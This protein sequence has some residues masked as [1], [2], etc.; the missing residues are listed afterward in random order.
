[1]LSTYAE[2]KN[3]ISSGDTVV[4]ILEKYLTA[5]EE[6]KNLNAFLEV[7]EESARVQ[8]EKVD[9]KIKDGTA[10]RLAGMVVGLKDNFC[11]QGHKVSASSK[12]LEGFESLFTGTAVERLINEDAIIIG[13]LN[14]DE[15]AM[16]SSNENSAFGPVRNPH[17]T[18][19]VP[20]GSSGGSAAAVAAGMCTVAL[21]SDT[22]GSIRQ[23][24]SFTGTFGLKPTYGR[25]SRHGLIAY[26]S[27]F[28]QIGPFT[29]SIDD[30][31]LLLEVMAGGDE[32][33]STAS[34]KP[35]EQY[36]E[37]E[38]KEQYKVAVIGE[39][40]EMDGIDPEVKEKLEK[41]IEGLKAKGHQVDTVSFPYLDYMV[42]TYYVL[43]TA[44]ASS[45]LS[46]FDGVHYGYRSESAVGVE[47]TYKKSRSEGF[48][49]EVQRRIMAGTFVLSH[50]YYDAF[51]T[52]G[53]RVRRVIQN[54]TNEIFANYDMILLPTTPTTA[55]E[56]NAVSD[57]ISMYL[58]DIYTV[59]ANLAGNPAISLPLGMH[60]SGLPFGVQ[61]IGDHFKEKEMLNFSRVLESI[62]E[63]E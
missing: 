27:S 45:N 46:R 53:Q 19:M 60:S 13:R 11:Y 55:F 16:G 56:L 36:T 14:C 20:G 17:N 29:N 23:P 6:Q 37:I 62:E 43:T 57:P 9:Q 48:G 51:Y 24:A 33:D 15:F 21:G 18:D 38:T 30:A 59:H 2:V 12:I 63:K 5:I 49:P 35:V 52:K 44:E 1:M 31:A 26:A 3:A 40:I 25:I 8:A 7:F 61:V 58:Q 41:T 42:P 32:F 47:D 28:D 34:S 54:K 10:G 39:S 4:S 50:G 22:G